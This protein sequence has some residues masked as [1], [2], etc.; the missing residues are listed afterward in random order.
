MSDFPKGG[1]VATTRAW[2]DRKGYQS[3][4]MGWEADALLGIEPE[5]INSK[6]DDND[7][8]KDKAAMLRGFLNTA[9]QS[10]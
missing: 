7:Q 6:F 3:Y 2:L 10:G 5:F 1:D 9:K 4:F 8:G